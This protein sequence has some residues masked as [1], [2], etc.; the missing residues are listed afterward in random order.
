MLEQL[1]RTSRFLVLQLAATSLAALGVAGCSTAETDDAIL[2]DTTGQAGA[3][4][5]RIDAQSIARLSPGERLSVDLLARDV[6]VHFVFDGLDFDRI[7]LAFGDQGK[8]PMAEVMAPLFAHPYSP[9]DAHDGRFVITTAPANFPELTAGDIAALETERMITREHGSST[10][11]AQPQSRDE[12]VEQTIYFYVD[13]VIDGVMHTILCAHTILVC[14]GTTC[15]VHTHGGHEYL[16]CDGHASWADAKAQCEGQGKSL[17]TINDAEEEAWVYGIASALSTQKWW[18]G[19]N[20]RA[21]EGA[22]VWDSGEPVTYTNWY[23]GEPNNAGGDE[24]CGQLNRF[25]PDLGWN[26]EPCSLHLRYICESTD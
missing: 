9:L 19:L 21:S 1:A 22:F 25:Y 4:N 23:P 3:T 6:M 11:K 15:D 2:E 7:D 16:F 20:D 24:D 10:P 26:D 13:I 12:C 8:A 17:L 14:G 5:V 18:I